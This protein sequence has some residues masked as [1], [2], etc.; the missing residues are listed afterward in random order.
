MGY[1]DGCYLVA[2]GAT[3]YSYSPPVQIPPGIY[4]TT[5][6]A[7]GATY[8]C[9]F[10]NIGS[11]SQDF[12]RG[13]GTGGSQKI[14][15][16]RFTYAFQTQGF[17]D[18]EFVSH[19]PMW[20]VKMDDGTWRNLTYPQPDQPPDYHRGR[21]FVYPPLNMNLFPG[22]LYDDLAL[23][24][25]TKFYYWY[26]QDPKGPQRLH[27][28]MADGTWQEIGRFIWPVPYTSRVGSSQHSAQ[29]PT[30]AINAL[31]GG[32]DAG[33]YIHDLWF[34]YNDDGIGGP[35]GS[36]S[37][38]SFNQNYYE[39]HGAEARSR[40]FNASFGGPSRADSWN[41]FIIDLDYA[42][43][44]KRSFDPD[45]IFTMVLTFNGG[46]SQSTI[47]TNTF[48]PSGH[49]G[50]EIT[51]EVVETTDGQIRLHEAFGSTAEVTVYPANTNNSS[52]QNAGS[53]VLPRIEITSEPTASTELATFTQFTA[54]NPYTVPLDGAL[55]VTRYL[56]YRAKLDQV[57]VPSVP[58][59]PPGALHVSVLADVWAAVYPF[60]QF[61]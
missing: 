43:W 2:P 49:P 50:G 41:F 8:E 37:Q 61:I 52:Y 40:C 21:W 29:I 42:R 10:W 59:T 18:W 45:D 5:G 54:T 25:S 34:V 38:G 26:T 12:V 31:E 48:W 30:F 56:L 28:K 11:V 20:W 19:A 7:P 33:G 9:F 27:V 16:P 15:I 1:G 55:S 4:E 23:P 46:F 35:P 39:E 3:L 6:S 13:T 24:G 22:V 58:A 53:D 44:V 36:G 60:Y 57:G 14:T 51:T 32:S 17:D 47:T